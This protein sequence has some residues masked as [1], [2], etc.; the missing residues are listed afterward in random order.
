MPACDSNQVLERGAIAIHAV[1]TFDDDP[2][3]PCS[4]LSSP[5]RN[6]IFNRLG[7]V[8]STYPKIGPTGSRAFVDARV[9]ERIENEQIAPLG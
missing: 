2:D 8:V 6:G 5:V 7:I 4:P 9:H 1:E 3:A